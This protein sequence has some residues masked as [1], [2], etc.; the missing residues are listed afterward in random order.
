MLPTIAPENWSQNPTWRW[1]TRVMYCFSL[2]G[3]STAA[4]SVT[5][6]S[7]IARGVPELGMVGLT[8]HIATDDRGSRCDSH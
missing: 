4:F 7:V 2:L 8:I 1:V 5:L 3:V 6:A